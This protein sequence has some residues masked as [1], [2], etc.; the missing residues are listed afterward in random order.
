VPLRSEE[1]PGF[2]ALIRYSDGKKTIAAN[3]N[4][5]FHGM[6]GVWMAL[7]NT[8]LSVSSKFL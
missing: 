7:V 8:K 1:M 6:L 4:Q 2:H 5:S 3:D